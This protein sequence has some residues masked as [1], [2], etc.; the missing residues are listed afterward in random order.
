MIQYIKEKGRLYQ[1]KF[2]FGA[3]SGI[4]TNLAIITGLRNGA[5]AKLTIIG[6]I[7]IV[8]IADNISDSLGIHV[9]QESECLDPK[10]VWLSTATNF[11]ARVLVSATFILLIGLLP[12]KMAAIISLCWGLL[13]LS[14]MSYVIAR[15]RKLS[16]YVG[17][18]E[19]ILIASI[20]IVASN[21][22]GKFLIIRFPF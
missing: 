10:E 21:F 17:V 4:I 7:L 19:H 15:A 14:V 18:F 22:I 6:S 9:Y 3:T 16:P 8:A 11:F 20:V 2:S 13:L 12:I 5:H 1:T